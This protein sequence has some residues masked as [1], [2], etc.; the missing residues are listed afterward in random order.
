[1]G[2][3]VDHTA[4]GKDAQ[5]RKAWIKPELEVLAIPNTEYWKFD[6]SGDFPRNVWVDE[7]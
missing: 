1:V 3:Q 5:R 6:D 7:S 2:L 4:T